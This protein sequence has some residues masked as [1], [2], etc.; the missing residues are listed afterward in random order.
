MTRAPQHD[1]PG[2]VLTVVG[3]GA[4]MVLCCAGPVLLAS[5]ALAGLGAALR[6]PWLIAISTTVL[7][8]AIVSTAIRIARRRRSAKS[9]RCCPPPDPT[10]STTPPASKREPR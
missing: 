8:A 5:G 7:L 9:D 10:A 4:L 1:S 6:N 2:G 3:A